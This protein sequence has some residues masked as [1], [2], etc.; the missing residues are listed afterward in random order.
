M[1]FFLSRSILN[2]LDSG[3]TMNLNTIVSKQSSKQSDTALQLMNG[4]RGR[5]IPLSSP[6]FWPSL[7]FCHRRR[8]RR[9]RQAT[10]SCGRQSRLTLS[11]ILFREM[12][13]QK[14]RSIRIMRIKKKT[15]KK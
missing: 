2:T 9:H 7:L 3:I 12:N 14:R 6:L 11:R 13:K 4:I 1:S 15:K 8:R 10:K 5:F